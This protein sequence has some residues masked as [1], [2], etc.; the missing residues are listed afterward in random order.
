[1]GILSTNYLRFNKNDVEMMKNM[2]KQFHEY[3]KGTGMPDFSKNY[4]AYLPVFAIALLA[5]QESVDKLSRKL[6][7]LTWAIAILTVMLTAM[8][9]FMVI[10]VI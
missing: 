4:V 8:T 1:M 2:M 9:L 3:H 6:L 10:R 5:S 7:W